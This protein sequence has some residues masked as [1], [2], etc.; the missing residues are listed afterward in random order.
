MTSSPNT[1]RK[2]I[3]VNKQSAALA[4]AGRWGALC[5]DA[6]C[7]HNP[8]H[9][10]PGLSDSTGRL[11]YLGNVRGLQ[12]PP[13]A[14]S[15]ALQRG[16]NNGPGDFLPASCRVYHLP[17][18]KWRWHI[19]MHALEKGFQPAGPSLLLSSSLSDQQGWWLGCRQIPCNTPEMSNAMDKSTKH[20]QP[21]KYN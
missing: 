7:H 11:T 21:L 20:R 8:V 17:P 2:W 12:R 14:S 15:M 6:V 1:Q 13:A 19:F 5:G 18:I 10:R 16:S 3:R 4:G 9:G